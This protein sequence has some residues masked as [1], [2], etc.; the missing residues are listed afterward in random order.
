MTQDSYAGPVLYSV[1]A[2][3]LWT[4]IP[5]GI[6]LNGF[7]DDYNVKKSFRTGN[8][9][10]EKE[11]I[12]DLELCTTRI[13]NWMNVNRLKMNTDKMEFICLDQDIIFLSVR[14]GLL[15]HVVIQLLKVT[16]LSYLVHGWVKICHSS[17][18]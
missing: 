17:L 13:N 2:S 16:R 9:V 11:V 5:K 1:Y 6:D 18:I 15:T 8:K 10:D 4:V 3:T 12:S 14:L 7:A